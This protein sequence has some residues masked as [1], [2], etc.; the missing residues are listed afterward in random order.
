MGTPAGPDADQGADALSG[1]TGQTDIFGLDIDE[2]F[3]QAGDGQGDGRIL[4]ISGRN[5]DVLSQGSSRIACG[6]DIYGDFSLST[7]RDLPR[8]GGRR[9][10]SAGF[11]PGDAQ[12]RRPPIVYS[13]IMR[14]GL[15][16][17]N[18]FKCKA[19]IGY[20]QLW[21]RFHSF[22]ALCCLGILTCG[23]RALVCR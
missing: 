7:G 12:E 2:F 17:R 10:A 20:I 14:Y 6:I 23:G 22:L 13:E 4:R 19:F 3:H 18:I 1:N 9:A 15:A 21:S 11:Y 8:I 5:H 16:G